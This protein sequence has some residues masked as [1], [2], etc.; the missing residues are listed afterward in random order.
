MGFILEPRAAPQSA[1]LFGT[2]CGM[3]LG[4]VSPLPPPRFQTYREEALVEKEGSAA[5]L[6][7]GG[8]LYVGRKAG[9]GKPRP[10]AC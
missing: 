6:I 9:N 7:L 8:E 5:G 1:V 2:E 10:D 3:Q 4:A